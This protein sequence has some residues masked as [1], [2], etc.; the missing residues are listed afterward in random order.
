[1]AVLKP[2]VRGE[3]WL[4]VAFVIDVYARRMAGSEQD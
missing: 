1:M 4:Y 3:G 2:S